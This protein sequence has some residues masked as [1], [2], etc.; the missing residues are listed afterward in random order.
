MKTRAL[1]LVA[2]LCFLP[3]L[4]H[5]GSATINWVA[6]TAAV[7]SSPLTGNQAV[8]NYQVWVSASPI[9]TTTTAPATA[10]LTSTVTTT[11]QTLST[12]PGGTIYARVKA[13]NGLLCSDFSAQ[14]TAPVP[15]AAPGIPTS[16]TITI[17]TAP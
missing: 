10:T 13:C 15:V 1:V 4:A 14:A 2:L 6:P 8:T 3:L 17:S 7:D 9:A 11:T 12:T 16:V 5:A